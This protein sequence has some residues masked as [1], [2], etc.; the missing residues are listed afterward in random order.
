MYLAA[1]II[2]GAA[3]HLITKAGVTQAGANI[4]ALFHP[5]IIGGV[6]CYF[7][8]FLLFLPWLA[9][10]PVG[11]AVPAAGLTYALVAVAGWL[12][13]GETLTAMQ[14]TGIVAVGIGVWML[15]K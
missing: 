10:R 3:G 6:F 11:A 13:R 14:I 9:A 1:S 8:S 12:F 2:L 7:L 4:S 15:A 5:F